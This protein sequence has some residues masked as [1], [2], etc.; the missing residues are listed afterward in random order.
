MVLGQYHYIIVCTKLFL[1][2]LLLDINPILSRFISP[3]KF[4]F[5][6]GR[7]IHESIYVSQGI[8][9]IKLSQSLVAVIKLDLSKSY[10]RVS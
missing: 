10:E 9:I 7:K 8:H 2:S 1:R 3:E 4:G 5:L 6:E